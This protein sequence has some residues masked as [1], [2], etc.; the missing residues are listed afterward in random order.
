MCETIMMPLRAAMPKSV[1]K[2]IKEATLKTPPDKKIPNI[3]PI[4]ASG[5]L[6]RMISASRSDRS[7]VISK[8]TI[9]PT[10]R[11]LKRPIVRE[12]SWALS[13]WPP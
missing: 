10:T 8:S 13:N 4:K 2:P 12:A 6:T 7:T 5:K 1:I 11:R 9:P 3:P